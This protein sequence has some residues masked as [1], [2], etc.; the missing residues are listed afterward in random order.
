MNLESN[1]LIMPNWINI[2]TIIFDFDGIFTNN[3]VYV[4]DDGRE[5][6]LCSRGDGL[7]I[8][9]LNAFIKKNNWKLDYFILSKEKNNVVKERAK[10]MN[11]KCF[12]G[13]DNKIEFINNYAK[14]KYKDIN[15]FKN[16]LI[17]LG[18]DLN[19]LAA[20]RFSNFS[21]VPKDAHP[22]IQKYASKVIEVNGGDD[23]VRKF[24]EELIHLEDLDPNEICSLLS[25]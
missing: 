23:F 14:R 18:N 8:N 17:Y 11:L 16:W 24:I 9:L 15:K 4:R 12:S 3:K 10:K 25:K 1:K 5:T 20:I 22:L 7:G 13:I 6:I 21:V 19:D 2:H